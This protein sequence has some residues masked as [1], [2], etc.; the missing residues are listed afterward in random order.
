MYLTARHGAEFALPN[1]GAAPRTER[2]E[3]YPWVV[4]VE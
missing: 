1:A 3:E 2:L 4:E